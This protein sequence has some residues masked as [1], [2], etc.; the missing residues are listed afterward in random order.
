MNATSYECNL[1]IVL[2]DIL[3]TSIFLLTNHIQPFCASNIGQSF[4]V[5]RS[6]SQYYGSIL[7][8]ITLMNYGSYKVI[9]DR[10]PEHIIAML[11]NNYFS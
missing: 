5:L 10:Y 9:G 2:F 3:Y 6:T 7:G 11:I 1:C 8:N 4:N